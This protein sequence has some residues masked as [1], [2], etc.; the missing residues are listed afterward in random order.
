[1][2]EIALLNPIQNRKMK[3]RATD[4]AAEDITFQNATHLATLMD[5]SCINVKHKAKKLIP[6]DLLELRY[7]LFGRSFYI[8]REAQRTLCSNRKV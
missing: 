1:M 5:E 8:L 6:K 3:I 2:Q 7:R 4:V